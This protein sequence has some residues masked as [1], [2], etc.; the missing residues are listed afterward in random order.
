MDLAEAGLTLS[1]WE[2]LQP[3]SCTGEAVLACQAGKTR[4]GGH[5]VCDCRSRQV[6]TQ[7]TQK[8]HAE[9]VGGW[10]ICRQLYHQLSHSMATT[11]RVWCASTLPPK[12][13]CLKSPASQGGPLH[14][15]ACCTQLHI[16]RKAVPTNQAPCLYSTT[17]TAHPTRLCTPYQQPAVR[18]MNDKE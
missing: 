17:T 10:G 16:K 4:V 14:R 6:R 12:G 13:L 11:G 18:S 9:K 7:V 5:L 3:F 1:T 2:G 15:Q 8:D